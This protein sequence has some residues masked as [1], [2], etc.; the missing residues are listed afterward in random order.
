MAT[1]DLGRFTPEGRPPQHFAHAATVGLNVGFA[2]I[3]A[4]DGIR[5]RLGRP[6]CLIAAAR[7]MRGRRPFTCELRYPDAGGTRTLAQLS[8]INAPAF[9]G[10]LRLSVPASDP[11]DRLLD[12]LTVDDIP[13]SRMLLAAVPLLLRST[14]PVPGISIRH[15]ASVQVR[16][17]EPLE[18]T[19][20][21]EIAG[22]LP[23]SFDVAGN[24]L[25]V[26]VP[27]GFTDVD[28]DIPEKGTR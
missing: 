3:A 19:L 21:G 24:A 17:D 23:G 8:V 11:D 9:G 25:R 22:A 27:P 16:A 7:T 26:I 5:D 4:Q 18:V 13:P 14:R 28:D 12:I 2:R 20:D 1:V 15:A 10:P 6:A